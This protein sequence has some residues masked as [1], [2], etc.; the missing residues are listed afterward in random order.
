MAQQEQIPSPPRDVLPTTAQIA[1]SS[2]WKEHPIVVAAVAVSGTIALAVLLIKEVILPTHTAALTNQISSLSAEVSSLREDKEST[3][4]TI[5]ILQENI[6]SLNKDISRNQHSHLEKISD[7]EDK[8]TQA[9]LANLFSFGNPYPSG[10]GVVRIGDSIEKV[11]TTYPESSVEKDNNGYWTVKDQHKIFNRIVY[12]YDKKHSHNQ[13][14]H[15]S[16]TVRYPLT[17]NEKLLQEK[18]IEAL[19]TPKEWSMEDFFSWNTQAGVT[20]FKDSNDG[21]LLMRNDY[22]PGYWPNE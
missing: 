2:N 3:K 13:I 14:S 22:F 4:K 8:L 17:I 9:Q 5:S 10:L 7:L 11:L 15:I 20:L 1:T 19:G 16:F 18:L 6:S 21:F 12:Y